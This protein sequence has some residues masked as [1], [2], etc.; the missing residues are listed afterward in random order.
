MATDDRFPY[1]IYGAQQDSGAAATPSRTDYASIT[2]RDWRA[3]RRAA[4]RADTS[5][6]TPRTPTSSAAAAW[7]ASTG[8]RCRSRTWIRRSRIPGDYRGEWTLPLAISPREPG[9]IYFGNQF[10]F[11]STDGGGHWEKISPDL[12][13]E[14]PGVPATLDPATAAD[15]ADGR[16]RGA[17]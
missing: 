15:S 6:P 2:Q 1:W 14:N 12:T 10:L 4:A 9:A 13:R 7:A 3:D 5:L 8:G 17:A 11:R 16:A